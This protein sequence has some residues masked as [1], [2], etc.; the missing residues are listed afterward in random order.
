MGTIHTQF[1]KIGS[2]FFFRSVIQGLI[3]QCVRLF[4]VVVYYK[5]FETYS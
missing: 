3:T 5:Q 2:V 4:T 1:H